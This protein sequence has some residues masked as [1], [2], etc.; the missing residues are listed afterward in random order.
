ELRKLCWETN[1]ELCL[2]IT[3]KEVKAA[4]RKL[5][6]K[7]LL[8]FGGDCMFEWLTNIF[9]HVG[10]TERL[11]C[12][13]TRGVIL[14][15]WKRKGDRLFCGNHRGITLLSIPGKLFTRILLTRFMKLNQRLF[16]AYQKLRSEH[17]PK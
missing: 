16:G 4:L 2:R 10:G 7:K 13:W 3:P 17:K 9:N 6:N 15:F 5:N 12:E 14:P 1:S 8:K 11:P